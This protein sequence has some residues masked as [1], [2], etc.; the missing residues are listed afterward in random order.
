MDTEQPEIDM[1]REEAMRILHE[2]G[3]IWMFSAFTSYCGVFN[4]VMLI[5]SEYE[6]WKMHPST[7]KILGL[8]A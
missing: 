7:F 6:F 8:T 5:A 2:S 3:L 1:K 4:K